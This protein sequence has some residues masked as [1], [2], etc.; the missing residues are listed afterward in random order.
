MTM[1]TVPADPNHI[2][3]LSTFA[4]LE[5]AV[6]SV[7][8][9]HPA[10]TA[11]VPMHGRLA[12][13]VGSVVQLR[14]P[15]PGVQADIKLVRQPADPEAAADEPDDDGPIAAAKKAIR[16]K[17]GDIRGGITMH[18]PGLYVVRITIAKRWSTDV[19]IAAFDAAALDRLRLPGNPQGRLQ[20]LQRIISDDL[21]TRESI[22]SAL[23]V[24]DGCNG[25]S[26]VLLGAP[27]ASSPPNLDVGRY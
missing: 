12:A 8:V 23:E 6:F 14:V 7:N 1:M 27:D 5:D 10:L 15:L 25:I 20:R 24:G 11:P 18:R 9:Q 13:I 17:A 19:V 26:G 16:A 3:P 4:A 2:A 21:V 22:I